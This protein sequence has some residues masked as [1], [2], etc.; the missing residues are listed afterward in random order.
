MVMAVFTR[1]AAATIVAVAAI[2]AVKHIKEEATAAARVSS[3]LKRETASPNMALEDDTV[4]FKKSFTYAD[5][6]IQ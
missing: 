2:A 3:D 4:S 1:S 6:L 5:W